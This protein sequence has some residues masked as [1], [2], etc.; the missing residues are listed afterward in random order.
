[1][2]NEPKEISN[3]SLAAD[4]E[5]VVE[6]ALNS[7]PEGEEQPEE[8][9]SSK[10]VQEE[11]AEESQEAVDDQQKTSEENL[12]KEGEESEEEKGKEEN[13]DP[14]DLLFR[15]AYNE[16]KAKR[17]K[18]IEKSGMVILPKEQVEQ[19]N[20]MANSPSVLRL[21]MK[22]QGYTDEAINSKLRD[23]GH[24]VEEKQE[25]TLQFVLDKLGVKRETLTDEGKNYV[26]T[27]VHDVA[28]IVDIMLQDRLGKVLPSSI[29]PLEEQVKSITNATQSSKIMANIEKT[30][31]DE[32]VLDYAKDVEPLL[33][34][35][36][37]ENEKTKNQQDF[38]NYFHSLNHKL[39]I[40]RLKV[41]KRKEERDIKKGDLR[42]L[43]EGGKGK[44][45]KLPDW[46]K[47]KDSG[48][49]ISALLDSAGILQ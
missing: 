4:S 14:K 16:G 9:S 33:E 3:A 15:K 26:D 10:N 45:G 21:F 8:S 46:D 1:M 37:D 23:L 44:S 36:L 38:V 2:A 39:T 19:L 29:K 17:D 22:D 31:K 13:K 12:E 5:S 20:K 48:D 18:E 30:V 25:D 28:K 42:N 6:A 27:V 41:G 11:I 35:W 49:N 40:E 43:G 24:K 32:G 47:K 34:K 7:K